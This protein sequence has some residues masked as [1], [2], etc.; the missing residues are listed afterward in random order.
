MQKPDNTVSNMASAPL[1]KQK[2]ET[3]EKQHIN[4][5]HD[6]ET[7]NG[8]M[9]DVAAGNRLLGNPLNRHVFSP[10]D[11]KKDLN[12]KGWQSMRIGLEI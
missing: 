9:S 11:H 12:W 1:E 4:L 7:K 10:Q 2:A 8:G 6:P 3:T 5:D